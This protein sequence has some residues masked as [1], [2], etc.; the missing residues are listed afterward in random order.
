VFRKLELA[1]TGKESL[2]LIPIP[3]SNYFAI[4]YFANFLITKLLEQDTSDF[5]RLL[6]MRI[7]S[8][9]TAAFTAECSGVQSSGK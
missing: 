9:L 8:F 3:F 6:S 7:H 1:L 4:N 2:P 5:S